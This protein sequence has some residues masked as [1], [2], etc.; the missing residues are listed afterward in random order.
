MS[1]RHH[2]DHCANNSANKIS[3]VGALY[4]LSPAYLPLLEQ[5]IYSSAP[6]LLTPAEHTPLPLIQHIH[7]QRYFFTV[8]IYNSRFSEATAIIGTRHQWRPA[9]V[10]I[11]AAAASDG[12]R[13]QRKCHRA[14]FDSTRGAS[15][16]TSPISWC[17]LRA[18]FPDSGAAFCGSRDKRGKLAVKIMFKRRVHS[19]DPGRTIPANQASPAVA[20]LWLLRLTS[21]NLQNRDLFDSEIIIMAAAPVSPTLQQLRPIQITSK[22][23]EVSDHQPGEI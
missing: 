10:I 4:E 19:Q 14:R 23:E 22:N 3:I 15:A 21:R 18:L 1:A 17:L 16:G 2:A 8:P 20:N 7:G 5:P 13:S 12:S 11:I 6:P 9:V